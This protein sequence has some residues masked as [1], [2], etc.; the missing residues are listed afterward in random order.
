MMSF[1][2]DPNFA[3]IFKILRKHFVNYT[4]E[5]TFNGRVQR[6]NESFPVRK[7]KQEEAGCVK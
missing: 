3:D 5:Q 7:W 2:Y 6:F 1:Y 4:M